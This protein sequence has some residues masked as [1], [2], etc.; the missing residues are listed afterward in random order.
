MFTDLDSIG[1]A[2]PFDNA[3]TYSSG[4]AL[5]KCFTYAMSLST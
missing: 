3:L 2:S 4:L 5:M 1:F